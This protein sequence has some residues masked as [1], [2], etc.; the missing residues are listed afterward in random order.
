MQLRKGC[1][2]QVHTVAS[3]AVHYTVLHK[4]MDMFLQTHL[5]RSQNCCFTSTC[6]SLRDQ[7]MQITRIL[8]LYTQLAQINKLWQSTLPIWMAMYVVYIS[9][10]VHVPLFRIW[11]ARLLPVL[12]ADSRQRSASREGEKV[13]WR[14]IGAVSLS[15]SVSLSC[16]GIF[17]CK[18]HCCLTPT[19]RVDA[20]PSVGSV[21]RVGGIPREKERRPERSKYT[22]MMTYWGILNGNTM[23]FFFYMNPH[24]LQYSICVYF[25]GGHVRTCK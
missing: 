23:F 11:C 7:C 21:A 12:A 19:R 25:C 16:A 10:R 24:S 6:E 14:L 2:I 9:P 3:T 5:R 18:L 22:F 15:L 13:R 17:R 4:I 20:N 1:H 8:S